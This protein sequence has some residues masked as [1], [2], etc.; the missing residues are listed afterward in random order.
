MP[1]AIG[2]GRE[3]SDVTGTAVLRARAGVERG[4]GERDHVEHQHGQEYVEEEDVEE[5][6]GLGLGHLLA[7]GGVHDNGASSFHARSGTPAMSR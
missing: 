7:G 4:H 1:L 3:T 5:E 6:G 2:G